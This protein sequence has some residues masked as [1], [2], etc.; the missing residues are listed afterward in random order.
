MYHKG[1]TVHF[2]STAYNNEELTI[3]WIDN[4]LIPSLKPIAK[5]EVLLALNVVAFY[6]TSTILQKFRNSYIIPALVPLS[7][8]GLLQPLDTAINQ[9]FKELLREQ[10]EVVRQRSRAFW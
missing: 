4:E 3:Q 1:V 2:N 5:D 7:F 6:K 8:I 9:P 10:T